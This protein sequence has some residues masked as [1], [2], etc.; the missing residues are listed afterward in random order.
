M[1]RHS[2]RANSRVAFSGSSEAPATASQDAKPK[3]NSVIARVESIF[4]YREANLVIEVDGRKWHAGRLPETRDR[5]RDHALV[6]EGKRVLRFTWE[7]VVHRPG[8]FL[9]G[10]RSGTRLVAFP[11]GHQRDPAKGS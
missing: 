11:L 2:Q 10:C 4:F 6:L 9:G 8:Y 5:Q 1:R 7:D 3:C